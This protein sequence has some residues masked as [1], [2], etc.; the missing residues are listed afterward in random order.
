LTIIGR[1]DVH[2]SARDDFQK[3]VAKYLTYSH[4]RIAD[5]GSYDV[6]GTLRE[7]LNPE[8]DYTGI[9]IAD[10]PNVDVVVPAHGWQI[11]AA[12][13]DVVISSQCLEH[14]PAPWLWIRDVARILKPNGL[15]YVCSP[16]TWHYHEYPV[17]CWRP[18]PDGL[19]ALFDFGDIETL[20]AYYEGH[21]TTGI[22][23]KL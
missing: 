11:P 21:D 16:N 9:D 8:W 6:N 18:W 10:G 2:D 12:S 5:V 4:Y 17:D 13:F 22:G 15:L 14:V 19:R 20:E 1:C 23:R 3:F 7:H